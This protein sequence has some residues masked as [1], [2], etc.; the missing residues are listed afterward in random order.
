MNNFR[1]NTSYQ[2]LDDNYEYLTI[3]K[4]AKTF[5]NSINVNDRKYNV[6]VVYYIKSLITYGRFDEAEAICYEA[7][8]SG[9]LSAENNEL[10]KYYLFE[11]YYFR[12]EYYKCMGLRNELKSDSEIQKKRNFDLFG[13][14]AVEANPELYDKIFCVKKRTLEGHILTRRAVHCKIDTK[15][16][17]DA[18]FDNYYKTKPYYQNLSIIRV[19]RCFNAGS[20]DHKGITTS[21]DYIVAVSVKDDPKTMVTCFFVDSPGSLEYYDITEYIHNFREEKKSIYPKKTTCTDK[22]M[23]RQRKMNTKIENK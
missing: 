18:I 10:V 5:R 11:I 14:I 2:K 7:L 13:S 3:L 1:N 15:L 23:A 20:S 16:M 22:F 17:I 8:D 9:I 19:F 4:S 21:C 6:K 12:K